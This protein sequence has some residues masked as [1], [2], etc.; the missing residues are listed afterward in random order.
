MK[1]LTIN[2]LA[3]TKKT[4]LPNVMTDWKASMCGK[5]KTRLLKKSMKTTTTEREKNHTM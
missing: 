4:F 5:D 2:A 1:F 3:I